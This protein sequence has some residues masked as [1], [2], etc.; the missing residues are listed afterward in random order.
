MKPANRWLIGSKRV[1]GIAD[2]P[3]FDDQTDVYVGFNT[4]G[5]QQAFTITCAD[6]GKGEQVEMTLVAG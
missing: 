2:H 3:E 6:T 5:P 4:V 1:D